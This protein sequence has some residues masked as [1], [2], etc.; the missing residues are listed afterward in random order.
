MSNKEKDISLNEDQENIETK[1]INIADQ[2]NLRIKLLGITELI[3]NKL[4]ERVHPCL[5]KKNS[6]IANINGV[7]NAIVVDGYPIGRSVLQGEGAGPGP[8]ASALISDLCSILRGNIKYPF[9][10]SS[11]LRK[12]PKSVSF[13]TYLLNIV[14]ILPQ[15]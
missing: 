6:Y 14:Q 9:G 10:V 4:F 15:A 11:F 7:L 3:N 8:T 13:S 1:D 2:L 12:K 5:V